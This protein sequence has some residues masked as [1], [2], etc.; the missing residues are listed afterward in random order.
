MIAIFVT[1][2]IIDKFKH[3]IKCTGWS[4]GIKPTTHSDQLFVLK[5]PTLPGVVS[6]SNE[7]IS[8][9]TNLSYELY[10]SK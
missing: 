7:N 3:T 1:K 4:L 5:P 10:A 9:E 6:S 2:S 8:A